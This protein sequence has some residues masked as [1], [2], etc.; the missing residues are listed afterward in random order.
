[1]AAQIS[2][3]HVFI[4]NFPELAPILLVYS[5]KVLDREMKEVCCGQNKESKDGRRVIRCHFIGPGR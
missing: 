4:E 1:M 5:N 3:N 2:Q